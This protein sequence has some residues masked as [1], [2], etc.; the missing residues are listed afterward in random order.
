MDSSK[1]EQNFII[2]SKNYK[3]TFPMLFYTTHGL[4]SAKFRV[5]IRINA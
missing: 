3:H 4:R 2:T 5:D 1:N